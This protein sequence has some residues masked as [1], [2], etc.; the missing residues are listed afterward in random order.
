MYPELDQYQREGYQALMKIARQYSGAFL[1]DGVGLGKTFIGMM[2]IERLVERERK[3][4]ALFVPEGSPQARLGGHS[5]ALPPAPGRRLQ[6]PR[7]LQP[8]RPSQEGRVPGAPG[9]GEGEG[10]RHRDRRGPPLPQPRDKGRRSEEAVPLLASVRHRG[11]QGALPL[12]ATPINNRLIDL[13]H[14]IELFSRREQDYFK[15]RPSAS[16]RSRVISAAWRKNLRRL[17]RNGMAVANSLDGAGTDQ[18]EAEQVLS[19][20]NLFRSLVVQRSRAYVKQSQFSTAGLRPCSPP[21]SPKVAEYSVKKTY[22]RLLTMVEEAFNKNKPLFSLAI[23]YPLAY[24]KG[25]TNPSIPSPRDAR[26]RSSA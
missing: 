4:V 14:M 21:R 5:E 22:G 9:A 6:Q 1:C 10:R 8:H 12:T 2:V 7:H 16:T 23:Y 20:D 25:P 13:Q 17:L 3:R 11:G 18:V 26:S 15:A 19:G 24:Y